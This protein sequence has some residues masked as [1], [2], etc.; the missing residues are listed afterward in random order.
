MSLPLAHIAGLE[1]LLF[2]PA[3]A[4]VFW[5]IFKKENK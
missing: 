4:A 5:S 2:A 3:F 1:P